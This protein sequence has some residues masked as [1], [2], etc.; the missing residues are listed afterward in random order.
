[1]KWFSQLRSP[2]ADNPN[3]FVVYHVDNKPGFWQW[4]L[5]GLGIPTEPQPAQ[6]LVPVKPQREPQRN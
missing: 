2:S 6:V 1:M 4:L 5:N 3:R